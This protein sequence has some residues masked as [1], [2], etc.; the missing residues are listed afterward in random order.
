MTGL[1]A[2]SGRQE[3]FLFLLKNIWS[4]HDITGVYCLA[5]VLQFLISRPCNPWIRVIVCYT[6]TLSK[7]Q[8]IDWKND[9]NKFN[10]IDLKQIIFR[11][12]T[13]KSKLR[14]IC[15]GSQ[16]LTINQ[17]LC[18]ITGLVIHKLIAETLSPTLNNHPM[19]TIVRWI[20]QYKF[21]Q[22]LCVDSVVPK[23]NRN[24]IIFRT[25]VSRCMNKWRRPICVS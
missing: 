9:A 23:R 10:A 13:S 20:F 5:G 6:P 22:N 1:V 12:V 18:L 24:L 15:E 25:F 17:Y 3:E 7:T 8:S 11:S 4:R 21:V 14:Q 19:I 16:T 2:W